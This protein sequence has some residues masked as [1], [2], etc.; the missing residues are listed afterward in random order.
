MQPDDTPALQFSEQGVVLNEIAQ[1]R[2][3]GLVVGALVK[4]RTELRGIRAGACGTVTQVGAELTVRWQP[5][6][7]LDGRDTKPTSREETCMTLASVALATEQSVE[8]RKTPEPAKT[9]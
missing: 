7:R 5:G 3:S 8:D 9:V 6:S 2:A 1:A 4:C